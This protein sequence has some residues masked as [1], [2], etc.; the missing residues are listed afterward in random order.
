MTE[1]A[2]PALT[3][4]A[5][6]LAPVGAADRTAVLAID[7]PSGSGKS[8]LAD[9]LTS[10]FRTSG[11]SV[12]LVHMDDLCPGWD[13]LGRA[14]A[15]LLTWVLEPL[16]RN[17]TARYRRFDWV[18]DRFAEWHQLPPADLVIIEGVGAG[19]AAVAPH[20]DLLLWIEAPL[21]LRF[22]RGI[23]RDGEAYRPQWVRW[24]RQE[25]LMF[26]RE[27]TRQRAAV[28]LDGSS[29]IPAEPRRPR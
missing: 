3:E 17:D 21:A 9:R 19:A 26:A 14:P 1:P 5:G 10:I 4:L 24:A 11:R 12:A 18:A 7:G 23:A 8:T 16:S 28:I 22:E 2:N 15:N 29:P 20:L 27:G 25:V 6:L 13:G